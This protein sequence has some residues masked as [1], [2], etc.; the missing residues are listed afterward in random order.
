MLDSLSIAASGMDGQQRVLDTI[1][2]NLAN[3]NTTSYKKSK[4]DFANLVYTSDTPSPLMNNVNSQR[5]VGGLDVV[6]ISQDFSVG[7]IKQTGR[8]L[9]LAINGDGFFELSSET[10]DRV[11]TRN[12][13]FSLN[14]DGYIVDSTGLYLGDMIRIPSDATSIKIDPNGDVSALMQGDTEFTSVGSLE[15]AYFTNTSGLEAQGA[16]HYKHTDQSGDPQYL[17][18]SEEEAAV[19]QGYLEISNV[20][21]IE[22]LTSM[23]LA[24]QAYGLNSRVVQVSDEIMGMINNLTQG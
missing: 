23:M 11:F 21:M 9:D 4:V 1:S 18:M 22:E 3:I 19:A 24:Q 6:S 7:D 2:N 15:L 5:K 20:S 16:G 12:G 17:S 10:G 13:R 14:S 8:P